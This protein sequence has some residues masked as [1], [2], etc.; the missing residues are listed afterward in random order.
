MPEASPTPAPAEDF[1]PPCP[2]CKAPLA[3]LGLATEERGEGLCSACATPVSYVLFPAR[4]RRPRAVRV[5][6]SV[7]GDSTC[8][9]HPTNHA[10]AICDD[11]GRYLCAVCEV[12]GEEGR[13]LCPPCVSST[14][15]KTTRKADELV[16]YDQLSLTSALV[17]IIMW[18]VTLLSAPFTLGLVIYG[19]KKPRSLVRPGRWRFIVA[20]VIALLQ[21][22]GWV[23]LG[24][25]IWLEI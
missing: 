18:P 5:E 15:K 7:E 4:R 1:A 8:Y 20:A 10:A 23:T 2:K 9:F 6:R 14:R 3:G 19:W 21:L 16:T 24:V 13:R 22:A 25:N 12:S 11:C 17:P